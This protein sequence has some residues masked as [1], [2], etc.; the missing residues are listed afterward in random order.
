MNR[1]LVDL[2][3]NWIP[4]QI[5]NVYWNIIVKYLFTYAFDKTP[6]DSTIGLIATD[7][8]LSLYLSF[9]IYYTVTL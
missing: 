3:W 9:Y 7:F 8:S 1:H 5:V 6:A 4:R 2:G